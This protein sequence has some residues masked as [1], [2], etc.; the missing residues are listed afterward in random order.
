MTSPRSSTGYLSICSCS[1]SR[2]SQPLA[3]VMSMMVVAV[4]L[5]GEVGCAED[6]PTGSEGCACTDGGACDPGLECRSDL[7]VESSTGGPTTTPCD[8][9]NPGTGCL[10]ATSVERFSSVV[11]LEARVFGSATSCNRVLANVNDVRAAQVAGSGCEPDSEALCMFGEYVIDIEQG[12]GRITDV[13]VGMR[14]LSMVAIG[15][16]GEPI[17]QGCAEGVEVTEK[18]ASTVEITLAPMP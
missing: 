12:R 4:L 13:P 14:T 6:C 8:E 17:G 10:D 2:T 7:C 9:A 1:E 3:L 16:A 5:P 18:L 11:A 15:S